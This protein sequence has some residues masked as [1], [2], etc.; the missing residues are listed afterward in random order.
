[1]A[2]HAAHTTEVDTH[3]ALAAIPYHKQGNSDYYSLEA[4]A[5]RAA[6]RR[7]PRVVAAI[8]RWRAPPHVL[9]TD[10]CTAGLRRG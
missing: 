4:V 7:D 2:G 1:M 3:E 6:L 5:A 8:D 10:G 9:M